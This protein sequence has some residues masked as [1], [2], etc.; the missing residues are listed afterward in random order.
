MDTVIPILAVVVGLFLGF[1]LSKVYQQQRDLKRRSAAEE[2][3]QQVTQNAQREAENLVKEAKIEVKDLLFQAK[4][5]LE[6]KEK[7]KRNEIQAADRKIIQREEALERKINQFEKRDE[8]MRRKERT[9]KEMEEALIN[10]AAA[11]DQAIKEHRLALE[12]VAGITAE[13]AKR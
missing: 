6:T 3:A 8:E 4:A 13:E 5:E 1:V 9:L 11:C 12:Q 7:E 2:Q 10:K